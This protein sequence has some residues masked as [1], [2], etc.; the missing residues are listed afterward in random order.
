MVTTAHPCTGPVRPDGLTFLSFF[1]AVRPSVDALPSMYAAAAVT[2][3]TDAGMI[4]QVSCMQDCF[5]A[6]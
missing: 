1:P 2:S 4:L 3:A 6:K 5:R